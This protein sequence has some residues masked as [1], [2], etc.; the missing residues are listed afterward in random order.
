MQI[1]SNPTIGY[2][3]QSFPMKS[4][5][6]PI[7]FSSLSLLVPATTSNMPPATIPKKRVEMNEIVIDDNGDGDGDDADQE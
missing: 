2:P 6:N 3:G 5:G 4:Y 7:T 1:Q